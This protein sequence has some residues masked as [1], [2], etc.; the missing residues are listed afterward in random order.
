MSD[1]ATGGVGLMIAADQ[2]GGEVHQQPGRR[3]HAPAVRQRAGADGA[4]RADPRRRGL[5]ARAAAA[6]VNVNLA[7]VTDTVPEDVGRANEPI[8]R[9][10]RQYGSDPETVERA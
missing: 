8:G 5:G 4:G 3:V 10:G 6:G 7:P 2:E 9:Y 1:E